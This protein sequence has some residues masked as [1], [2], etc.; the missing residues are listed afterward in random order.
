MKSKTAS[1]T[2]SPNLLFKQLRAWAICAAL[3][4]WAQGFALAQTITTNTVTNGGSIASG[5][6]VIINTNTTI[7]GQITNNGSL[8]FQ[9]S[10]GTVDPYAISGSGSVTQNSLG[11][12]TLGASNSYSGT[13]YVSLGTLTLTNAYGL[14]STNGIT[15]IN[16]TGSSSNGGFVNISLNNATIAESFLITN[17]INSGNN[18]ALMTYG[19]NTLS[20]TITLDGNGLYRIGSGNNASY[21]NSQLIITGQIQRTNGTGGLGLSASAN[22]QIIVNTLISNN[23]GALY[24]GSGGT[25]T[26]NVASNQIGDVSINANSKL[27]LGTNNALSATNNLLI[28]TVSSDKGRFDLNGFNQTINGLIATAGTNAPSGATNRY[29]TNSSA[30]LSTLTVGSGVAT[31]AVFD[32]VINQGAGTIALIKNGSGTQTLLNAD[33]YSGGT[34]INQ[35]TMAISNNAAFGTGSVAFSSNATI[36]ALGNLSLTNAFN[37]AVGQAGTF[38]VQ[39]FSVTNTGSISGEGGLALA[40]SGTLVLTAANSYSGGTVITSGTLSTVGNER[41]ADNGNVSISDGGSLQLGGNETIAGLNGAGAASLGANT[42]SLASGSFSGAFSGT[43]NLYK[44][45]S[46]TFTISGVSTS[47]TGT[48]IVNQGTVVVASG[49]SLP[50]SSSAQVNGGA[51]LDLTTNNQSFLNSRIDGAVEGSGTMTVSGTLSG[52]GTVTPD[53]VVTGMHSPGS[54]SNAGVQT[55]Q[56]NLVYQ[57]GASMNWQLNANT[58]LNSPVVYDQVAVGGNLTFNGATSLN[59]SFN[60]AGSLVNWTDSFWS[61]NHS[62]TIYQVSGVSSEVSNLSITDY[63]SLLDGFGNV[64]GATLSGS[65]FSLSQSGQNVVVN[66]TV[67]VPE[68]SV[69]SLLTLGLICLAYACRR[70]YR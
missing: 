40:G 28:G 11:T 9:Q 65:A 1:P 25:V 41:L 45:G 42:L 36:Q 43:G 62:W 39:S 29:V 55:F 15:I 14:G 27:K 67:A 38:D 31:N 5:D 32:G 19:S 6:T 17:G 2:V 13:T 69:W 26:L 4:F 63:F 48:T 54:G 61:T 66:Y 7:T 70:R 16:S 37:V 18:P 46:G 20:G 51:R 8:Q 24:N 10:G 44:T 33:V 23:Y 53:T 22:D 68:P 59:L 56:G 3:L 34:T 49:G 50:S 58:I 52:S 64:F 12:T 30:L 60:S 57:P 35:G 47:Y 21:S